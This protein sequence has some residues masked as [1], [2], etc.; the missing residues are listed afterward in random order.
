MTYYELKKVFVKT[1]SKAALGTLLILL[2]VFSFLSVNNMTY[3]DENGETEKGRTAAVNL[4]QE[5]E[6]W[7]GPLT[8][9][10][11][12]RVIRENSRINQSREARSED[13]QEQN[14]AYSRTQGYEDIRLLIDSA[15]GGFGDFDY[16]RINS[17]KAEDAELFY[18]KRTE[19]LKDWLA[20]E[21]GGA[22]RFTKEEQQYLLQRYEAMQ[23]PL[24]YEAADGWDKLFERLPSLLM[25]LVL[26]LALIISVWTNC[27]QY[28]TNRLLKDA[29]L[30]YRAIRICLPGDD[31]DIAF[32]EKHFTIKR[33]E[34]KIR[35]VERLVTAFEDSVRNRIRN[36]EMAAYKDSLA[37][38]LFREAQEIRKQLDNPNSK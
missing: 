15:F 1:S 17:L 37:H 27:N 36:H 35:R 11:V 29:D 16:N 2:I 33:D 30:K 23:T 3:V 24:Y 7:E 18:P 9:E 21:N 20:D 4:R 5:K 19:N 34:E 14:K 8:E 38:R 26:I 32:L 10:T 25:I 13:V 12:A 6:R 31:P 22:G 28:R